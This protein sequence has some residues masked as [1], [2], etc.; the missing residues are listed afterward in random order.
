MLRVSS[1]AIVLLTFTLPAMAVTNFR[2]TLT[3]DQENPSVATSA[4]G[5]ATLQ[6]NDA[7]DRLTIDVELFGLDLDG[8]QTPGT[9]QDDVTLFHIHSAPAGTNGGVVFGFIGPNNDTN[10]DFVMDPIAGTVSS[11]WDLNE[12]NGTT[13]AAQLSNLFSEGLYLNVHTVANG[14]GEIRG[15]IIP[16]PATGM[17]LLLAASVPAA[18]IRRR[19]R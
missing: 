4:G 12:G 11:A 1:T 16:E 6:L 7:Q 19:R 2:A 10:G 18:V 5:T 14:G 3:G 13:L 17:L 15:Q 9:D 8:N